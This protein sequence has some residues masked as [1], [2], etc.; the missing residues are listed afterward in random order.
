MN[1]PTMPISAAMVPDESD[2]SLVGAWLNE[3]V[4]LG[5]DLSSEGNDGSVVGAVTKQRLGARVAGSADYIDLGAI[6]SVG[7]SPQTTALWFRADNIANTGSLIGASGNGGIQIRTASSKIQLLDQAVG[8]IVSGVSDTALSS[9]EWIHL[10]IAF[11][12]GN[13]GTG[14]YYINGVADGTMAFTG[15]FT[16]RDQW[17]GASANGQDF[18]GLIASVSMFDELKTAKWAKSRYEMAVPA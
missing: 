9:D 12:D 14:T 2:E 4:K 18:A 7:G 16:S 1:L 6:L 5:E 3:R 11:T 8:G 15:A 13:G 10:V 17:I